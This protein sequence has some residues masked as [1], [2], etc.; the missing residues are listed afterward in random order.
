MISSA[1]GLVRVLSLGLALVVPITSFAQDRPP[2]IAPVARPEPIGRFAAD[3]RGALPVFSGDLPIA[4]RRELPESALPGFGLGLDVGAHVYPIR[5]G[6]VT[7]GVGASVL[8]ARGSKALEAEEGA[9]APAAPPV[10]STIS[11][12]SPQVSFNF[13]ARQGWSY[14][15][16]GLG[17]ATLRVSRDDRPEEEGEATKTINYGGGARW[18]LNERV[19]FSVDGRFYAMNPVEATERTAGHARITLFVLSVGVSFK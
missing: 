18:F 19:A 2:E 10:R 1:R 3:V 4:A 14:I 17:R 9:T 6:V 8:I 13:G 15:S 16:G 5:W 7:L 12:V 11:A